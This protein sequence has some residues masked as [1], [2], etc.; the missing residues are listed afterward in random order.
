MAKKLTNLSNL[1]EELPPAIRC[2]Q[3]LAQAFDRNI[4]ATVRDIS[5]IIR[6][7]QLHRIRFKEQILSGNAAGEWKDSD[8]TPYEITVFVPILD[9]TTRWGSIFFNVQS[10]P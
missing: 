4:L 2:N 9:I 3:T 1:N 6:S 8:G 10:L 7:S 5:T